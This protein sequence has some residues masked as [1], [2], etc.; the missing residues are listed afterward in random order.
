MSD[1]RPR[2]VAEST[3]ALRLP[4]RAG[5]IG[6]PFLLIEL[7]VFKLFLFPTLARTK[8]FPYLCLENKIQA[9]VYLLVRRM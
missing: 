6:L 1:S 4:N 5:R 9:L 2:Y 8:N 7:M 3:E